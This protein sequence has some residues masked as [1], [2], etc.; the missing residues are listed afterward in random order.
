MNAIFCI[1][2]RSIVGIDNKLPSEVIPGL[3]ERKAVKADMSMFIYV[4]T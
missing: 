3:A 4:E 1:Y 2:N